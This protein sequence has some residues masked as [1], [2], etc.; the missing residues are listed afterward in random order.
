MNDHEGGHVLIVDDQEPNRLL[1]RDLLEARGYE[2]SEA[3]SGP[4]AL[5][6]IARRRPDVV[7]LDVSMP[8]MDG[9]EVTRRL[10][11]DPGAQAIPVLLVTALS[12][13]E[14]RL[15]GIEAG[16]NDYLTKPIDRAELALRV[17]NAIQ[18]HRLLRQV[19]D[20]YRRL[21][22][23]EGLR[24][25]LVHMLVHDLRTPLTGIRM[26]LELLREDARLAKAGG[27]LKELVDEA[28]AVSERMTA[29]VNDMLDVSRL[30]EGAMPVHRKPADLAALAG[31][32]MKVAGAGRRVELAF[33][34]PQGGVSVNCDPELIRR[35]IANLVANAVDFSPDRSL[36]K[37]RVENGGPEVRVEV[38]DQGPGIPPEFHQRIFEKFGQADVMRQ[39]VKHSSGLG[40]TFCKLAVEA[41]GGRIGVDSAAG[42]GSTFW[43]TIPTTGR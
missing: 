26:Y 43:F 27:G 21:R 2:V 22:D 23:L 1:L 17:R 7:L 9:F 14:H 25:N 32:A 8:G 33:E 19:E 38:A 16:A 42:H 41:H 34:A 18:M 31:E 39:R 6:A 11:E 10:R 24:D 15:Q 20:Q 28:N 36:V 4:E 5:A 35:V 3:V 40:L 13:R 12:A 29:M 37:V 30:E